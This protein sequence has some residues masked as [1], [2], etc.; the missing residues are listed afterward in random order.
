MYSLF[1][2]M[3][4]IVWNREVPRKSV[5]NNELGKLNIKA[6]GYKGRY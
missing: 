5:M 2:K 4:K 1:V 6:K 3:L